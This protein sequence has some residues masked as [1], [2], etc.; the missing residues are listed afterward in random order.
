MCLSERRRNRIGLRELAGFSGTD[1]LFDWLI[2]CLT[3]EKVASV[4]SSTLSVSEALGLI[5]L[6][7]ALARPMTHCSASA[8]DAVAAG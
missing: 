4:V 8:G 7:N 6:D 1:T 3:S 2:H 5:Q